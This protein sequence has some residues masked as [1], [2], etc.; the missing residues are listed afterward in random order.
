MFALAVGQLAWTEQLR[1]PAPVTHMEMD[2]GEYSPMTGAT[3]ELRNFSANMVAR[4]KTMPACFARINHVQRGEVFIS[5]QSLTKMFEQKLSQ[6]N[7]QIKSVSVELRDD[8][9]HLKGTVHKAVDLPFELE[10]PLSTDGSKLVLHVKR[11]K[12][13]NSL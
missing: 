13:R 8:G 4:G 6:S 10:G 2:K 7:S 9:V 11:S 1:C 12:L 3:F 5:S